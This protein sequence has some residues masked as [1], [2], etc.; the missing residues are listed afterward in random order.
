MSV[1]TDP[2][3]DAKATQRRHDGRYQH[4]LR[5]RLLMMGV[6]TGYDPG[7]LLLISPWGR[8]GCRCRPYGN[9]A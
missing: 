6:G 9:A 4:I 1:S 5:H 7:S 8:P 2:T 3:T